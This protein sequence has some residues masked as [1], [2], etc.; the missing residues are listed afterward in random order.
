MFPYFLLH[1]EILFLILFLYA[2]HAVMI[3]VGVCVC[4]LAVVLILGMTKLRSVQKKLSADEAEV[5]MAWDDTALNITVNPLEV[6]SYQNVNLLDK[7]LSN[8]FPTEPFSI[9]FC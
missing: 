8:T 2:G 6:R 3:I 5:E 7:S 4:L 9:L 1:F